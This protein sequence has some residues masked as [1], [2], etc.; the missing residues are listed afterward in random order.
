MGFGKSERRLAETLKMLRESKSISAEQ[1]ASKLGVGVRVIWHFES[2]RC[3]LRIGTFY[4]WCEAVDASPGRILR[5]VYA[6]QNGY[7]QNLELASDNPDN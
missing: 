7:S 4:R 3:G 1:M 6:S 2:C 5:S